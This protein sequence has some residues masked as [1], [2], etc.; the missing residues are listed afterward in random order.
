MEST[1]RHDVRQASLDGLAIDHRQSPVRTVRPCPSAA[2]QIWRHLPP[3]WG[4]SGYGRGKLVYFGRYGIR[5]SALPSYARTRGALLADH[6][7]FLRLARIEKAKSARAAGVAWRAAV[8]RALA[9]GRG[10]P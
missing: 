7:I 8:A 9:A 10:M 3:A 1:S 2:G 5:S 4:L 6:G